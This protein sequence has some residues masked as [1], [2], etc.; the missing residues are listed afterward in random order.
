[1][2]K[3]IFGPKKH[4]GKGEPVAPEDLKSALMAFF[5]VEGDINQHLTFEESE[6]T[7][8]GFAAVWEYFM[9]DSDSDGMRGKYLLNT[10]SWWI[11]VQM[12][13]RSILNTNILPAPNDHQKVSRSTSRGMSPL[14]LEQWMKLWQRTQK[15][16]KL[17]GPK[18]C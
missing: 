13:K 15:R 16:L 8:S 6:K 10:L 17:G 7:N 5:P 1:M 2:F 11:S 4:E 18:K 3:K 9:I 12:K 14:V